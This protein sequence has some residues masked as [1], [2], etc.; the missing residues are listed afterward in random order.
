M[1]RILVAFV[2][3]LLPGLVAPAMALDPSRTYKQRPEKYNMVYTAVKIPTADG[4]ELNAWHFTVK[5]AKKRLV[6]ISHNGQGNMADSLRRVDQFKRLGFEVLIYDYRGFGESADFEIDNGM[7]LYPHFVEDLEGVLAHVAKAIKPDET[8]LYGWGIGAGLS[9]GVGW[10]LP[11]VKRIIA[12]T[13]FLTMEDLEAR[14]SK[15]DAPLE[16]PFAGYAK[17]HQ[18]SDAL[19]SPPGFRDL[20][21]LLIIGSDD[22]LFSLADMKTLSAAQPKHVHRPIHVVENPDRKDNFRVDKSGYFKAIGEFLGK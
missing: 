11:G 22:A 7:Y 12:D 8:I 4:T 9:L 13:P 2:F 21:V 18:P 15:S 5:A 20:G 1:N 17:R 3:L 10:G 16:V 6:V 19:K 14:L